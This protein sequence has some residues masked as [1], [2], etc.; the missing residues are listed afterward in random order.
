MKPLSK[1]NIL[2]YLRELSDEIGKENLKGEILLFGGAAMVVA[3]DARPSTRDV[4][5]IF[6]PKSKIYEM[7]K[8]VAERHD[9]PEGW[10]NDS[11][12]GFIRTD[13]FDYNLLIRF[14]NL[15]VYMPEPEYLLA[16]KSIS[17]RIGVESSDIDD[18]K[19]LIDHLEI[20]TPEDVFDIIK[21]YYP[22]D[23]VPPKTYYALE[24]IFENLL[25]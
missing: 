6:Q 22:R 20:K 12:K 23:Q 25:K 19:Y 16:M 18:I 11:V 24:E 1:E 10:L 5:A 7:S 2:N 14:E 4:D 3:F 8:R 15:S 9:L 17:M 13:A 21:K